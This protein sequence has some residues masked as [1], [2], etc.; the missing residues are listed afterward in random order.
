MF[1]TEKINNL[2]NLEMIL[3]KYIMHNKKSVINMTIRELANEAHVSTTTI[4]RFCKKFEC[5]GFTEFKVMLKLYCERKNTSAVNLIHDT[6]MFRDFFEKIHRNDFYSSIED[7]TEIL[8]DANH[9]IFWGLGSSGIM[10]KYGARYFSSIGK[11]THSINDPY[12]PIKSNCD[13]KC[14]IIILSESGES[15]D[16]I[17][18][19]LELDRDKYIIV[20]ITNRNDCTIS[21]LSDYNLSYYINPEKNG[22]IDLTSKIPTIFII[23]TLAKNLYK[24]LCT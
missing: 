7:I 15:P 22:T 24:K 18:R 9:V 17:K 16:L 14:V 2:N 3:Y 1:T 4:M 21:T 11:L 12:H 19:F 6:N 13:E 10:A 20:S 8:L 5:E 23:E